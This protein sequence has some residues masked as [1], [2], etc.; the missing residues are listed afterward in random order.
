MHD[1]VYFLKDSA[2]NDELKYSLR[3]IEK[4]L[5]HGKVFFYG[6]KT[7]GFKPDK[8]ILVN[9]KPNNKWGNVSDM[10]YMTCKNEE[11]SENFWLMND[12]FFVLSEI[13]E[14]YMSDTLQELIEHIEQKYHRPTK[15]TKHLKKTIK[16]LEAHGYPTYNFELHCPMLVNRD[17]MLRTYEMF[18]GV[19][20]HRSLYG[21]VMLHDPLFRVSSAFDSKV[22]D[23]STPLDK[24]WKFASTDDRSFSEGRIGKE[25]RTLF[26]DK[27]RYER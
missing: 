16:T 24:S 12:D 15:Y 3:S 9:Q 22:V 2:Y 18:P 8:H 1:V 25:I 4:N 27:C 11:I 6:G 20:G 10:L 14:V 7:I 19:A 26:K 21:N 17:C 23:L 13:D 5:P